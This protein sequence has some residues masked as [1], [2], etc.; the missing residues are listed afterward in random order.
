MKRRW[1]KRLFW[2]VFA[3][4]TVTLALLLT[5]ARAL[6]PYADSYRHEVEMWAGQQLGQQL[7][8][9]AMDARWRRLYPEVIFHDVALLDEQ[10]K[11]QSTLTE[12]SFSLDI[13]TLL[14]QQ[15]LSFSHFGLVLEKLTLQRDEQGRIS[16][17]DLVLATDG[18]DTPSGNASQRLLSWLLMQG[19]MQLQIGELQWL[20]QQTDMDYSLRDVRL[21]LLNEAQRHQLKATIRLPEAMGKSLQLA[22]DIEGDP[23]LGD[24]WQAQLYLAGEALSLPD[25]LMGESIA[26][27]HVTDGT[28]DFTLWS[29]WQASQLVELQG[30]LAF[31]DLLLLS[32]SYE[33]ERR[34]EYLRGSLDLQM[35]E[36]G[37]QLALNHV[38]ISYQRNVW[39]PSS[40]LIRFENH[41]T[42]APH[43]ALSSSYLSLGDVSDFVS[44]LQLLPSDLNLQLL[45]LEPRGELFDLDVQYLAEDGFSL[46]SDFQQ[47]T[48]F[49]MGGFP[50]VNNFSGRLAV[51]DDRAQLQLKTRN[52]YL[53]WPKVFRD[54]LP[55]TQLNG[56][57]SWYR[58]D[59][60]WQLSA[61]RLALSNSHLAAEAALDLQV[62]PDQSPFL[63]LSVAFLRGDA[64][65][66]SRYLPVSIMPE[67]VVDWLDQGVVAGQITGGGMIYH[68]QMSDFPFRAGEGRFEVE[69]DVE[70]AIIRPGDGWLPITEVDAQ[71]RFVSSSMQIEAHR[72]RLLDSEIKQCDVTIADMSEENRYLSLS[73]EVAASTPDILEY[74]LSSPQRERVEF[75]DMFR[76]KGRSDVQLVMEIPLSSV[77]EFA[78]DGYAQLNKNSLEVVPAK[79][80]IEEVSGALHIST[81]GLQ[82][83]HLQGVLYGE[84]LYVEG[85]TQHDEPGVATLLQFNSQLTGEMLA[86]YLELPLFKQWLLGR[87]E[88][89]GNLYIPH[90]QDQQHIPTLQLDSS[91]Q[92]LEVALP[93]VFAKQSELARKLAV[94]VELSA[95]N[96]P[97]MNL[98]YGK[99]LAAVISFDQPEL[100]GA[101]ALGMQTPQLPDMPGLELAGELSRFSL[102]ELLPYLPQGESVGSDKPSI[103]RRVQLKLAS[104][105]LFNQELQEV[106]LLATQM[107]NQWLVDVNSPQAKGKLQISE[108]I[109]SD[110]LIA[111]MEHLHLSKF[112]ESEQEGAVEDGAFDMHKLPA[113]QLD[114]AN[115][116][117]DTLTLGGLLLTT[118]WVEGNYYLDEFLL[119]PQDTRISVQGEWLAAP[120]PAGR[121]LMTIHVDSTDMGSSLAALG[122]ADAFK[123]GE[124]SADAQL[125]W[126]G[127]MVDLA[128]E[129]LSGKVKFKFKDGRLLEVEPGAGRLL[130]L[131]SIQMLPRR[132]LL[133]FSDLFSKGFSFDEIRG[134]YQ[135]KQG[136]ATTDNFTMIGPSARIDMLGKVDLAQRTYD[137]QLIITPFVTESLPLLS[138]LTGLATPQVAAAIFVAQKLFQDDLEKIAQFEYRVTG[139]WDEPEVTKV[140]ERRAK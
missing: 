132:L 92:G 31:H 68:G 10:G 47:L 133:D 112:P 126:A 125:E 128:T 69:F 15:Q 57:L 37:W 83:N 56:D 17:P 70:Q 93:G 71:V 86:G 90:Q 96:A 66:T 26:G 36:Q 61:P 50:G 28:L 110:P 12:L 21:S 80:P 54:A 7:T 22:L 23:L 106:E 67:S 95:E 3:V 5:A 51:Q 108:S 30:D 134:N 27:Q 103:L 55:V 65:H 74:L 62:E 124:G 20:D 52:G 118:N 24:D 120:E 41:N 138:F 43:L 105:E 33:D 72:G 137:Q 44:Y 39:S 78:F 107:S 77:G 40:H 4:V 48:T 100:R 99:Q 129:R 117:Y 9:K 97:L 14:W 2:W 58:K 111:N 113:L 104:L 98:D 140:S 49:P 84:P 87:S 53:R 122:Y 102:S 139:P 35:L 91:L 81:G 8:I 63:E 75:L 114:V 131:L 115:F 16:S 136:T 101:I 29:N 25:W 88:L 130:G 79:L 42:L 127:G 121:T 13:A 73:G 34:F 109:L 64:T 85:G 82:L 60:G 59:K 19:D 38:G 6:F 18:Q 89:V 116:S 1:A 123:H 32:D 94:R 11:T 76:V 46:R 45:Q 119:T 135:L